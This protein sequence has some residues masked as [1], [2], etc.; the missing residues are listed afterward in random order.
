[1]VWERVSV[2]STTRLAS[3]VP[4]GPSWSVAL[5]KCHIVL[6]GKLMESAGGNSEIAQKFSMPGF[7]ITGFD[8]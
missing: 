3:L 7:Y 2:G 6:K 1:M 8:D 5:L 4:G